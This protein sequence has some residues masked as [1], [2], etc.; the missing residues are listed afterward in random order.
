VINRDHSLRMTLG[1]GD[2][3][4]RRGVMKQAATIFL[5]SSG[6]NLSL[7]SPANAKEKVPVTREAISQAFLAVRYELESPEGGI[8]NL[9]ELVAKEDFEEIMEFTKYYDLEFRKARM[10]KAR[11]LALTSKE[12]K[13]RAVSNCNAV[14]FDL[15]GMN[16]A[17]RPGQ[18]DMNEVR[19]YFGELKVDVASFLEMEKE[20]D[21]SLL[22]L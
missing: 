15:I 10:V 1:S 13:D 8:K 7:S 22:D 18:H 6:A 12:L 4:S 17:S 16:K 11:K 9:E 5:I 19:K 21:F 3:I 14:T 2:E 20:I